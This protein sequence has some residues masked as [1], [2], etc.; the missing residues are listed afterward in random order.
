MITMNVSLQSVNSQAKLEGSADPIF[1][2]AAKEIVDWSFEELKKEFFEGNW[3]KLTSVIDQYYQELQD[4]TT[5]FSYWR[6]NYLLPKLEFY[7][8]IE[9]AV[10]AKDPV[11]KTQHKQ[12]LAIYNKQR[13]EQEVNQKLQRFYNIHMMFQ[14]II[15]LIMGQEMKTIYVATSVS[16]SKFSTNKFEFSLL[17]DS[18]V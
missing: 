2:E 7:K 3:K 13:K 8:T 16:R 9:E 5:F 17:V 12:Y 4:L 6:E 15:N 1:D 14:K 11:A 18:R 10:K